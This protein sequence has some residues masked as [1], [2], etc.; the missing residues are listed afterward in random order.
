MPPERSTKPA[1][2]TQLNTPQGISAF[3]A[4]CKKLVVFQVKAGIIIY[5]TAGIYLLCFV[6]IPYIVSVSE[7]IMSFPGVSSTASKAG[8]P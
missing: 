1:Q 8:L 5:Y 3:S 4:A 7:N 6:S 2:K